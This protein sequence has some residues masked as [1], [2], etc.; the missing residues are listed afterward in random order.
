MISGG[1]EE[2][3]GLRWELVAALAVVWITVYFCI[4][5]GVRWT[6]K[7]STATILFVFSFVSLFVVAFRLLL[8]DWMGR[9]RP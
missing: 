8:A 5:K 6:G 2:I 4:W 9:E 7:V 1:V 3:G